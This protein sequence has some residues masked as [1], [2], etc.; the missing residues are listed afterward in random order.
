MGTFSVMLIYICLC[1]N[2]LVL[3]LLPALVQAVLD[4]FGYNALN[5]CCVYLLRTTEIGLDLHRI[6][7]SSNL[8]P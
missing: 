7:Q 2:M 3:A 1:Y 8:C 6:V 4:R 5:W